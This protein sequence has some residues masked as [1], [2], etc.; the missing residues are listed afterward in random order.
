MTQQLNNNNKYLL[1][2]V[3]LVSAVQK[4]ESVIHICI[5]PLFWISF[6]LGSSQ[7][8]EQSFL[9]YT[10]LISYLF[11]TS[12]QQCTH[13]NPNLPIH[14]TL[15]A[16]L[17]SIHLFC[18]SISPLQINQSVKNDPSFDY[19]HFLVLNHFSLMFNFI[20]H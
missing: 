12:C 16:P 10:V 11:Y 8:I 3:M 1:Y 2:N 18:V 7:S 9:C 19:S 17:V 5:S 13:V 6:P 4:S 15:L 14:P 20:C